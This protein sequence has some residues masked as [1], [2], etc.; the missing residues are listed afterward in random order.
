MIDYDFI[1]PSLHSLDALETDLI[2]LPFFS[3]ERPLEGASGLLDWRLCGSLSRKIMAGY[4]D[5]H[6]GETSLVVSPP[7][8]LAAGILLVG[9]G[10]SGSFD[11]EVAA[12][13]CALIADRLVESRV[14][15]AA[16]VLPG[17][18]SSRLP[19]LEALQLWLSVEIDDRHLNEIMLI[20]QADVHRALGSVLDGLR[21][22]AE[23]PIS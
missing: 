4:V 6:E 16:L 9:L 11:T 5:G 2:V 17:R 12:R 14:S 1:P 22:Q 23:S 21:R 15:T 7:K 18:S 10:P 19:S 20:E 3:D 13:S 8:L